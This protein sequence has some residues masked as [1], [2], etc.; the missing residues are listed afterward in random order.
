M[1][2]SFPQIQNIGGRKKAFKKQVL[3]ILLLQYYN[4]VQ[5]TNTPKDCEGKKTNCVS[6]ESRRKVRAGGSF[7][8]YNSPRSRCLDKGRTVGTVMGRSLVGG[9]RGLLA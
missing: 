9:C 2:F 6:S 7:F 1:A 5:Q 8:V 3:T 4:K